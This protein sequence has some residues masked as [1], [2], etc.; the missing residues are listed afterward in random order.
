MEIKPLD[1]PKESALRALPGYL[2]FARLA[3]PHGE[4]AMTVSVHARPR[5]AEGDVLGDAD[6]Y[7][8]RRSVSKGRST[9]TRSSPGSS[10]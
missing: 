3:L 9:T 6:P 10:R 2:A 8:L 1:L 4:S 7:E 5:R